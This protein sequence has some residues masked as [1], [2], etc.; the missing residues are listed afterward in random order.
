VSGAGLGGAAW[1]GG[2]VATAGGGAPVSSSA[3]PP[4]LNRMAAN[5][6]LRMW[7]IFVEMGVVIAIGALIVWWTWP[8]KKRDEDDA[9]R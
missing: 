6:S 8:K 2:Q 7:V 3:Q 5:R 1:Q 9:P 4:A